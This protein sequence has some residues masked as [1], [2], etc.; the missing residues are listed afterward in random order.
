MFLECIY[1]VENVVTITANK[2][3]LLGNISTLLEI[4]EWEWDRGWGYCVAPR[5]KRFFFQSQGPFTNFQCFTL[6]QWE[7]LLKL[8]RLNSSKLSIDFRNIIIIPMYCPCD[9]HT[10]TVYTYVLKEVKCIGLLFKGYRVIF[11]VPADQQC[12]KLHTCRNGNGPGDVA[13]VHVHMQ[14]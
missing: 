11:D 14:E 3:P 6:K 4:T 1:D 7:V 9:H 8:V 10:H 5:C 13:I 12:Y 2:Q